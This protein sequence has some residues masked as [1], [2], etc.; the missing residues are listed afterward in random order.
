MARSWA[1]LA[2]R[3]AA[4]S[5]EMRR[6]ISS[7]AALQPAPQ[8]R[9]TAYGRQAGKAA[10]AGR[11]LLRHRTLSTSCAGNGRVLKPASPRPPRSPTTTYPSEPPYHHLATRPPALGGRGNRAPT[12]AGR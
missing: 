7:A 9:A 3:L 11:S 1:A 8:R 12:P 4:T 6:V 10:V 5:R 2:F